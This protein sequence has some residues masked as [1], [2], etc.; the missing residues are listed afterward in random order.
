MDLG[1]RGTLFNS[2]YPPTPETQIL[3]R[4]SFT[5]ATRV[6]HLLTSWD[7][8][9]LVSPPPPLHHHPVKF[10]IL[11]SPSQLRTVPPTSNSLARILVPASVLPS[12]ECIPQKPAVTDLAA[13]QLETP[14]GQDPRPSR[15]T[16][17]GKPRHTCLL[18]KKF[19][20]KPLT[21]PPLNPPHQS[22]YSAP[23]STA[24]F[25]FFAFFTG[26][27]YIEGKELENFFQELEKARKGSGMVS[28]VLCRTV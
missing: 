23:R 7:A 4:A 27:G 25:F 18:T 17:G 26:N 12:T 14:W 3:S 21:S 13:V 16:V 15:C 22:Y 8:D 20:L 28:P 6:C 5:P 11:G 19:S 2:V 24:F 1:A 9:D 10:W